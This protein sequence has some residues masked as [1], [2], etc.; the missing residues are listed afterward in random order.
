MAV[1]NRA[2]YVTLAVDSILGQ[3]HRNLELIAVDDGSTDASP[4]ILADFA[5]RDSR[6][7]VHCRRQ[8]GVSVARNAGIA[9]ARGEFVAVMDDDDIA[10]LAR[11]EKQAAFLRGNPEF[12][13]VS[14]RCETMDED[15]AFIKVTKV[16]KERQDAGLPLSVLAREA[17]AVNQTTM[18]RRSALVAVG[19]Y[20]SFFTVGEDYDLALRLAEKFGAACLNETLYRHR[21]YRPRNGG[22][23]MSS[24]A[25]APFYCAAVFSAACRRGGM[26]DPVGEGVTAW[27]IAPRAAVALPVEIKKVCIRNAA[28]DARK[29]L[30]RSA[31]GA[32]E[33]LLQF[34][35][36]LAAGREEQSAR[37]RALRKI[38]FYAVRRGRCWDA[39]RVVRELAFPLRPPEVA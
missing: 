36:A 18:F 26:A 3:T 12:A 15:G 1:H 8:G 2:R 5:A 27:D 31:P 25:L 29:L 37:S 6:V 24:H 22:N 16:C 14:V 33:K 13:S 39:G 9:L 30:H 11:L 23:L 17:V 35:D 19:G 4:R 7:R 10:L 34:I 32:L 21:Q 38:L 20:R 28:T